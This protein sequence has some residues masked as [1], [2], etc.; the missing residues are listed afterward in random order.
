MLIYLMIKLEMLVDEKKQFES[1]LDREDHNQEVNTEKAVDFLNKDQTYSFDEQRSAEEFYSSKKVLPFSEENLA[2][3]E[4]K[5][6]ESEDLPSCKQQVEE[7]KKEVMDDEE[8]RQEVERMQYAAITGSNFVN[9]DLTERK[10]FVNWTLGNLVFLN[11][12]HSLNALT[13]N[14]D[15]SRLV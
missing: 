9:L 5:Q 2:Y 14:V 1:D 4:Q 3:K 12:Y 10:R 8:A 13:S 7:S 11:L 15:Y 6:E